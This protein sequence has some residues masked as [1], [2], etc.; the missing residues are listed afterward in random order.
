MADSGARPNRRLAIFR[1]DASPTIGGGHVMRC[2]SLADTL[3]ARGWRCGFAVGPSSLEVV[4]Q[5]TASDHA[6]VELPV[7]CKEESFLTQRW[8]DGCELLIFD[9]YGLQRDD[10]LPYRS[11]AHRI[12]ILDDLADRPHDCDF[13]L[14]PDPAHAGA[15]TPLIP[16][17]CRVLAGPSWAL[18][19]EQYGARRRS[20]DIAP[21]QKLDRLLISFGSVDRFGLCAL[22]LEAVIQAG[23]SVE[24][25]VI[26]SGASPRLDRVRAAVAACPNAR[27]H[28]DSALTYELMATADLAIG[29]GGTTA[30]ERCCLGLPAIVIV[31]ARNQNGVAMA[32]GDQGAAVIAGPREA[33]DV[34]G[35]AKLLRSFA[36]NGEY[37]SGLSRAA[38]AMCDGAGAQR[39]ASLVE[40]ARAR[41]GGRVSFR[42]ATSDDTDTI[43]GWQS[44]PD[45]R[46]YF[47]DSS[48][49]TPTEH[50]K[51]L[52][53]KIAAP[54]CVLNIIEHGGDAA[55]LLRLDKQFEEDTFEV[56]ILIAPQRRGLGIGRTALA[57][58]RVLLPDTRFVA[59]VHPANTTSQKLFAGAGYSFDDG[60]WQQLARPPNSGDK[61]ISL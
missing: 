41:D 56:S 25:D 31:T 60:L 21:R 3:A 10:E 27:L 15:Y 50:Q 2:L 57:L 54:S 59:E 46:R 52:A 6:L 35:I 26:I 23:I 17:N 20:G 7:D 24:T 13:L 22:A 36:N 4:P 14:D 53:D 48:V 29:A 55:G 37:L 8:S 38:F 40:D 28:I 11:W 58:L 32:L 44:H 9:H 12:A 49:P 5:L 39:F 45:T 61:E 47:R 19:Q 16:S 30:W 42:P 34:D 1:A 18:L 43:L 51:W 33:V